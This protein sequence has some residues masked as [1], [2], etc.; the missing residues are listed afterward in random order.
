KQMQE[1][2][3]YLMLDIVFNHTS[4]LHEWAMRAKAGEKNFQDFFYMYDDRTLP[5]EFEKDMPEIFPESAPGNFTFVPACEKWV[6]T[7]FHN[8]QWDLNY[9]NPAVFV[10]MLDTV[11]F[12][13]NLGVDILRIDAPAFIW[14]QIGTTCQNLP[15]AHTLLQ[16]LRQCVQMAA[17]GMALLGEAIVAPRQIMQYFGEGLA[18]GREC[19]LAYNATQ[20]A[21]QWDM[22]ATGDTRIM[23]AAQEVLYQKPLNTSWI[24]YTRCHDDIGLGYEDA[25]I[26]KAGFTAYEHRRFLQRYYSGEWAGSPAAGALFSVNP[27]TGDARISGTLASL[28]GLEKALRDENEIAVELSIQK[29]LLMQ[30]HSFFLGG[31]PMLFYGDEVGYTNDYSYKDDA[32]KSYDNRWM[33]RPLIDWRKN[34]KRLEEGT[35]EYQLY[36]A[37][38]KLLFIRAS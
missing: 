19:D 28:C 10:A 7:V 38:K 14:K 37:T 12:Y 5:D 34:D 23:L 13:A 27:K 29:I 9:T 35:I 26:Q 33:H 15:Q 4:H 21:L 30:A 11:L 18:R 2:G 1:S 31:I 20:M 24:T 22:L 17:P 6:M 8:Y 16:L 3:M 32:G 25:M 36:N